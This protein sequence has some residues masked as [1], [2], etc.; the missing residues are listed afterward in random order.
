MRL[1]GN[2]GTIRVGATAGIEIYWNRQWFI[3]YKAASA[4]LTKTVKLNAEDLSA[5]YIN[6]NCEEGDLT[7]I[8]SQGK[9]E[10]NIELLS[11]LAGTFD[12]SDFREGLIKMVLVIKKG[13]K[14]KARIGWR[15]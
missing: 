4:I 15:R 12:M 5:F 11:G 2:F 9:V 3:S 7:L 1:S 13:K 8:I 10:K 6:M 14:V